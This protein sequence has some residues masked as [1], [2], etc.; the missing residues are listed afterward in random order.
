[1]SCYCLSLCLSVPTPAP[2]PGGMTEQRTLLVHTANSDVLPPHL[3]LVNLVLSLPLFES[4]LTL[5]AEV[6]LTIICCGSCAHEWVLSAK[7][8]AVCNLPTLPLGLTMCAHLGSLVDG[9]EGKGAGDL[10]ISYEQIADE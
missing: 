9:P 6:A 4:N 2:S 5:M 10:Q 8:P 1:M 3:S 7:N